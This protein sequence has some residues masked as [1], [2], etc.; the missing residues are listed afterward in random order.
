M[1]FANESQSQPGGADTPEQWD[2]TPTLTYPVAARFLVDPA[3]VVGNREEFGGDSILDEYGR[4]I[5][6]IL[7]APA[8]GTAAALGQAP[9][10]PTPVYGQPGAPAPSPSPVAAPAPLTPVYS[11]D[12]AGGAQPGAPAATVT[13][14]SLPRPFVILPRSYLEFAGKAAL[15]Q[16]GGR[17]SILFHE[18]WVQPVATEASSLPIVL[19]HS[20]DTRQ[21]P[22]LQG[23]VKL[24]LSRYLQVDT[25]LWL[26]TAGEYLPGN[27]KMPA[28]PLGPPSLIIEEEQLVDVASAIGDMPAVSASEDAAQAGAAQTEAAGTGA[29]EAAVT[30]TAPDTALP[31]TA[32][33]EGAAPEAVVETGPVYPYR[34]AVLLQQSRRTR[35]GDVLYIDH[36]MLGLVIKFTPLTAEQLAAI[37]AEEASALG[38]SQAP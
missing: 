26:N 4:Q 12:A 6:T 32:G 10:V 17:Y 2:A 15:M 35:S 24:Y 19:D 5:I 11:G 14:P 9:S 25:N 8:P 21:W 29:V 7:T 36:P 33:A 31:A 28:P 20:G 37:A 18:T 16:R 34:H 22:R 27:W 23:S 1:V 13:A 3:Q 30:A 38:E